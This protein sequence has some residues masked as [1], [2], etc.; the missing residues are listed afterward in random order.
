MVKQLVAQYIA[1]Q[2]IN[3]TKAIFGG[4]RYSLVDKDTPNERV[5]NTGNGVGFLLNALTGMLEAY[6]A[7]IN[8]SFECLDD[9]GYIFKTYYQQDGETLSC[10]AKSRWKGS[11]VLSSI[12]VGETGS[13]IYNGI[14]Y[15]YK[16]TDSSHG[17]NNKSAYI[18]TATNTNTLTPKVKCTVKLTVDVVTGVIGA[19]RSFIINYN[20]NVIDT[21]NYEIGTYS[22]VY[23]FNGTTDSLSVKE[24]S[25]QG[26]A[27][28]NSVTSVLIDD[29]L[30][31]GTDISSPDY[32]I[33]GD[34]AIEN[35][36][37]IQDKFDSSNNVK[38]APL[39]AWTQ[40]ILEYNE[41]NFSSD[42]QII[43]DGHNYIPT[44]ALI[45]SDYFTIY[46]S[47]GKSFQFSIYPDTSEF[48]KTGWYDISGDLVLA[49]QKRG[50]NITNLEPIKASQNTSNIG[51]PSNPFDNIYSLLLHGNVNDENNVEQYKV[52]GAVAN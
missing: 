18:N 40:S 17:I 20:G 6:G 12:S 52:W 31:Y 41:V 38:L 42:S 44:S 32:V 23:T 24:E 7:S 21:S 13:L 48:A 43:V 10:S 4:T 46:T 19:Y 35:S 51:S 29:A 14:N 34:E 47:D 15:N 30:F 28:E 36:L 22:F 8:G 37:V 50:V 9:L 11:D 3:I 25:F 1:A 27:W 39:T 45:T 33:Y 5:E 16:R 49:V 26:L 2:Y